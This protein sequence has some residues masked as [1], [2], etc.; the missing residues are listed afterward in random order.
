MSLEKKV[1]ELKNKEPDI[2]F[3]NILLSHHSPVLY[4]TEEAIENSHE[5]IQHLIESEYIKENERPPL[6][7]L[8]GHAHQ[9][10]SYVYDNRALVISAPTPSPRPKREDDNARGF[11]LIE[12]KKNNYGIEGADVLSYIFD[13]RHLHPTLKNK[14]VCDK[15]QWR[16]ST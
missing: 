10:D 8:H 9:R 13:G 4:Q 1:L 11:T 16:K 7:I 2:N 3:L 15:E 6:L 14:Y 12:L 5:V